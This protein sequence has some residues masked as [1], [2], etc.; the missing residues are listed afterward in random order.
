MN[1]IIENRFLKKASEDSIAHSRKQII[2]QVGN[3]PLIE[4]SSIS[5]EVKPVQIFAKAE[6]FNP[7]GSVKDRAALN[8][9]LQGEKS[10]ALTK[11]KI[12]LDATSGNTGIAYA[13]I[14]AALGYKVKLAI[15]Q[16]AGNLFKQTLAAYG[17]ELIYSN[18]QHGS[19]GA[20]REAIRLYEKAPEQYFYPDQY[21][22]SANWLAHYDGTGAEIIRQTKGKITHFIAGLGT[23]GT[24]M[25]A[26]RRL[27]EFNEDIQLISVQPDSPLHGLEGLKHMKSNILPGIYDTGL[28][29]DNLEIS[30]EESQLLVKRL[31]KEEG[32]LVGMSAGAALA[33]ALI[34]AKRLT[35]GVIVVIFPDSAHKYFDQ[36]FWQEN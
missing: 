4:L 28:A 2:E 7:G 35:T 19:D 21:N 24:F 34:I 15:P 30:T 36:R 32:L 1:S 27:K 9:I 16:N 8:M 6:W 12:I 17:A 31:A 3:T 14:G 26:G 22:N 13:M 23:S 18:P 10:R 11:D 20:I 5:K 29:D 25:G 33:A